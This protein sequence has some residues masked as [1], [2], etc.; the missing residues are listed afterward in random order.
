VLPGQNAPLGWNGAHQAAGKY[1]SRGHLPIEN[2]RTRFGDYLLAGLCV[3]ANADLV[4]HGA[5]GHK[6]RSLAAESFRRAPL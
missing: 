1:R 2:V 6:E 3:Q 4:A 5:G